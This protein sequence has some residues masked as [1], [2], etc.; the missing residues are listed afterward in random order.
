MNQKPL[1][2]C[3]IIFLN[4]GE[5][6]FIE[7]IESILAQTYDNWELLLVDDGSTDKSTQIALQYAEKYPDKV[8]YLEHEGHQNRGMSAAR[9]LGIHH[10]KGEYV[11]FLD[12][13]DVWLPN[14]LEEQVPILQRYPEAAMLYGRT[15]FWYSWTGY[16]EDLKRDSITKTSTE[17]DALIKPPMQLISHLLDEEFYPCICSVLIRRKVFEEIGVFEEEF[18]T[19]NEDMVFHSKVFL[20]ASVFVSSK[21]WDWYR[22]HPNSY[23]Q[24]APTIIRKD[25]QKVERLKYLT[26]LERYLSQQEIQ[27]PQVWK[28]LDEALFP[29][30]HTTL[31]TLAVLFQKITTRI[32]KLVRQIGKQILP[33]AI[34]RFFKSQYNIGTTSD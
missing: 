27:S 6:F 3:I 24:S 26:W 29:Y 9:N 30:K 22:I 20:N 34:R 4:A 13:D 17:F 8:C 32:K 23:W 2:S 10:I 33:I 1:V 31:Y 19:A 5:S 16:P 14:K 28:A 15:K 21:C 18:R 11:A 7:A 12:A 25:N